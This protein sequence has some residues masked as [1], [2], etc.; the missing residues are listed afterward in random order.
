MIHHDHSCTASASHDVQ[1]HLEY[2]SD[3]WHFKF[4]LARVLVL[5]HRD[6]QRS[7][8][9]KL[10][11]DFYVVVVVVVVVVLVVAV[12]IRAHCT[13]LVLLCRL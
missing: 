9:L 6:L 13:V 1:V 11:A 7:S 10:G 3:L 5:L 12:V 4:K 2:D 8:T